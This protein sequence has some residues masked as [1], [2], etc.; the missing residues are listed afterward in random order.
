MAYF[1][2]GGSAIRSNIIFKKSLFTLSNAKHGE[3][4]VIGLAA[5]S[6]SK[7]PRV[8]TTEPMD[9]IKVTNCIIQL[10]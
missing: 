7:D 4:I 3:S 8:K 9:S 10:G 6:T 5:R 2:K 1:F